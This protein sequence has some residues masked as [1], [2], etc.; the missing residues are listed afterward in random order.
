MFKSLQPPTQEQEGVSQQPIELGCV[1]SQEPGIELG[2]VVSQ[3]PGIELGGVV[4]QE[5]GMEQCHRR[6]TLALVD[7]EGTITYHHVHTGLH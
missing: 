4:S 5:P 2:C 6:L 1:V 7:S 3:E